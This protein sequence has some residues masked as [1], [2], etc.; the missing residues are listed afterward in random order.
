MDTSKRPKRHFASRQFVMRAQAQE[1]IAQRLD[2]HV[3][4]STAVV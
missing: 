4:L 3:S 1:N 2:A